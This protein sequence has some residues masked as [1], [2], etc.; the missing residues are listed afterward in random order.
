MLYK[1]YVI[2]GSWPGSVSQFPTT[3]K[4]PVWPPSVPTHPTGSVIST[5]TSLPAHDSGTYGN[6]CGTKNGNQDQERIVGGHEAGVNEY[7]WVVALF[8]NGRQFCGGELFDELISK[9][10]ESDL[11]HSN[12]IAD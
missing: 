12:R 3:T 9:I 6:Y 11:C 4:R 2:P 8:N 5:T 10:H 1:M 7:P